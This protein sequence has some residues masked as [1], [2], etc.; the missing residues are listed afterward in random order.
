LSWVFRDQDPRRRALVLEGILNRI[1]LDGLAVR[2][3]FA[4]RG[5]DGEGVIEEIEGRH[6]PESSDSSHRSQSRT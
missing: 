6:R 5:L 3:A 1:L 4:L 2:E